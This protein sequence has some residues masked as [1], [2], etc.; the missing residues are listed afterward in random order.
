MKTRSSS[1]VVTRHPT[2]VTRGTSP[3]HPLRPRSVLPRATHP[4]VHQL[5]GFDCLTNPRSDFAPLGSKRP[6]DSQEDVPEL[7]RRK[8]A[9]KKSRPAASEPE[10]IRSSPGPLAPPNTES[11]LAALRRT[12]QQVQEDLSSLQKD[13]RQLDDITRGIQHDLDE[14]QPRDTL[15]FLEEHFTCAL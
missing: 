10:E 5:Q 14:A 13:Q 7:K 3:T 11:E 15:R 1:N 8:I 12:L 2:Q 9:R 6:L 4:I